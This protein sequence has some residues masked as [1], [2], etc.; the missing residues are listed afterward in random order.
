MFSFTLDNRSYLIIFLYLRADSRMFMF[1]T[2]SSVVFLFLLRL[3]NTQ[4]LLFEIV[5]ETLAPF[6]YIGL[7]TSDNITIWSAYFC[8]GQV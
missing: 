8:S 4:S 6:A 1:I 2:L 3:F 7:F 5:I